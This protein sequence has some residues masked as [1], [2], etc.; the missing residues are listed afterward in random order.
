MIDFWREHN[1][2]RTVTIEKSS[3]TNTSETG[4]GKIIDEYQ[5]GEQIEKY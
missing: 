5:M 3:L 4:S 2:N 1:K